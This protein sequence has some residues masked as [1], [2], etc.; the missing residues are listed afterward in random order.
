[1]SN[2]PI[3]AARAP[4][5]VALEAG[6]TYA[7]CTCGRSANQPFCNGA[8]RGTGFAPKV[9]Q[10]GKAGDAYLCQCKHTGNAP[11]CDGTHNT[12]AV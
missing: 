9:I 5:K 8:H 7:F 4:A 3:V 1:M 12:L 6:K 11:Y 10:A 2:Q